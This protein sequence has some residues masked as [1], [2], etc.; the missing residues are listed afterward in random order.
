MPDVIDLD[1]TALMNEALAAVGSTLR[2]SPPPALPTPPVVEPPVVETDTYAEPPI[3]DTPEPPAVP[4]VDPW[5][6]HWEQERQQ[7][8]AKSDLDA[9]HARVAASESQHQTTQELVRALATQL[10]PAATP[11]L[12]TTAP[13]TLTQATEAFYLNGDRTLLVEFEAQE[14]RKEQ[15][16]RQQTQQAQQRE[17]VR[18][19][20]Q[21][22][23]VNLATTY[24]FLRQTDGWQAM[25]AEYQ[26]LASDPL[27]QATLPV[28]P[29]YVVEL[30]GQQ[31][32]LRLAALAS[33]TLKAQM[34]TLQHVQTTTAKE[35]ADA[36]R[37]QARTQDPGVAGGQAQQQRPREQARH[38]VPTAMVR[39]ENA[40]MNNPE[41]RKALTAAGWGTDPRDQAK[42]L[43]ERVSPAKQAE[44]QRAYQAG[45]HDEVGGVA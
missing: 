9:L 38:L 40:L 43:A 6:Q 14:A 20:Q 35:T 1:T 7:L 8:A 27:T 15:Q 19:D 28:D 16:Q 18:Q 3:D 30:G 34:D 37:T 24:P 25:Q 42:R 23:L 13:I 26:R 39:G 41:V 22:L 44:W 5:R 33:R 29:R 10:Q 21:K 2:T 31:V 12:P 45:R 32:D 36:T 4:S 17:Q 11:P